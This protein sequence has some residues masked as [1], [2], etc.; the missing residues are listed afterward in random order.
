MPR[1]RRR[2]YAPPDP[3]YV[4]PAKFQGDATNRPIR[5]VV[6][7]GTV[8]PC[9]DGGARNVARYLT[10]TVT[11]P[12]SA[13]YIRDPGETVQVVY[14]GVVAYHAPPNEGSIGYEL[15][16]W[17]AVGNTLLPMSRWN[18][19]PHR[20]MLR[21]AAKDVARLCLAYGVPIRKVGYLGLRLRRRGICGHSDVSKAFGQT[22]HFDP[23]HFPWKRFIQMVRQEADLI[24]EGV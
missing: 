12:S 15:C 24:R 9:E 3:P 5:R 14:D 11:R 20:R 1:R 8:S 7:H 6:I 23:G 22:D 18:D 19:L 17:V 4:G 16:D 21:G 2:T 13:H 10:D